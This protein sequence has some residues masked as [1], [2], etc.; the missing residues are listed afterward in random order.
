MNLS[1][2]HASGHYLFVSQLRVCPL[3]SRLLNP[4]WP[5]KHVEVE[6]LGALGLGSEVIAHLKMR[7]VVVAASSWATLI[8]EAICQIE[9]GFLTVLAVSS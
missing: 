8:D 6:V 3:V 4:G 2:G 9:I 5:T 1:G 7:T